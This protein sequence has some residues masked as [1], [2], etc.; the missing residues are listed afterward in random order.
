MKSL[1]GADC[2]NC[3]M[4]KACMGCIASNGCPFGTQCFIVKYI[5]T[6]GMGNYEQF[7]Q[8]LISEFNGLGLPGMPKITE[9]YALVGN[10][11][12][13]EYP[14]PSGQKA[15]LLDENS[16]YLGNQVEIGDGRCYGLIAAPEFLLVGEYGENGTDPEIVLFKRR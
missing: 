3:E 15:K 5:Q 1:C 4:N 12:N 8:Q 7:K 2:A 10:F 14:L 9:L 11:V 16:V 6:G 13:L